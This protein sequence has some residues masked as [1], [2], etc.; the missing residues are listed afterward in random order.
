MRT[1]LGGAAL[2]RAWA[3]VRARVAKARAG[4]RE[5]GASA[6]EWVVISMIA[7]GLII[8]AGIL[9]SAAVQTKATNVGTCIANAKSTTKTNTC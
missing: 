7:I 3:G 1:L 8:G 2:R 4:E 5:R 9:I 6:V